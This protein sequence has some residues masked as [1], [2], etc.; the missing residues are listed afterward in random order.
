M[1]YSFYDSNEYKSTQSELTRNSWLEG[2]HNSQRSKLIK[3]VCKNKSCNNT[4]IIKPFNPKVFCSRSCSAIIR[5][6]G[7][8]VSMETRNKISKSLSSS[9]NRYISRNHFTKDKIKIVCLNCKKEVLLP[10][11]LARRQKYCSIH[12]N[13]AL[14]GKKTT[15]PKASKGKNGIRTDISKTI[16]F[17]ST[18]EANIARVYNLVGIK[19][20]YAPKL[21]DLG[22]HTYRPDFYLTKY[23]LYVEVK[24]FMSD[25]SKERDYLFREKYPN[26]NLDLILKNDY[27]EI[28]TNYKDLVEHWES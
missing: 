27:L 22:K 6:T 24:N 12:C 15:S 18:W 9:P 1:R 2:E 8:V 20:K 13:I 19:W 3:R 10:P 16:N 21:F 14:L 4:F 17:Y 23:K 7:R 5:N 11:Y 26:I 28:K 25:Y